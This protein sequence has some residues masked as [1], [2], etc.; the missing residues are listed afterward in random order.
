[1]KRLVAL[2]LGMMMAVSV[3]S[4]CG[5]QNGGSNASSDTAEAPAQEAEDNASEEGASTFTAKN[6]VNFNV[7]S[8][9]GGNSDLFS[10]TI[11]DI[12]TRNGLVD[13]NF[14]INNNTDGSGNIIRITTNESQDPDHTLLCFSAGDMQSM[15]DSDIGLTVDDFSPIAI[16]AA[17]KQ[18]I[19]AKAGGKYS[20]F[21]DLMAEIDAG[22]KINVGGTKSNEYTVFN[23]FTEEIGKSDRFNYMMYDSSA[24]S[25]T[26]LLGDHID[27]AMGSP[28]AAKSYVDSGDI[29]PIVA[30]S[31]TRFEAPLDQAPTMEELGY[32]CVQSPMWRGILA[33][34]SM[35]EEAQEYWS[36]VF[37]EVA[38]SDEWK[39]YLST[40]LLSEY[41]CDLET[42]RQ[43][44]KETQDEY[45]SSEGQ[46]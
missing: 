8:K 25:I 4:G 2:S 41:Y 20:S 33:P 44:M 38:A 37:G 26:A 24:E 23:M 45:F 1:M 13:A 12:C 16:M 40:Y 9:A 29:F 36:K 28:A 27:L 10:R 31:D 15:L 22:T 7:S 19:F 30:L 17:D 18:L 11:T 42:T 5:S 14:I 6:T 39:E 32:E 3:L 34:G 35:S 21:E 46:E 43:I